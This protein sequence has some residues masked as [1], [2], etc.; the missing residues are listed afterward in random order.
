LVFAFCKL[1][2]IRTAVKRA[3]DTWYIALQYNTDSVK[4]RQSYGSRFFTEMTRDG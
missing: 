3:L 4:K 1:V 2:H